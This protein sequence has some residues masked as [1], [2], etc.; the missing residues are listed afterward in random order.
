MST[1][2]PAPTP[3]RSSLP[4]RDEDIPMPAAL[5]VPALLVV[6]SMLFVAGLLYGD[7]DTYSEGENR[8][9]ASW[10]TFSLVA[11]RE[12]RYT[13]AIDD[14][15]ADHFPLREHFLKLAALCKDARGFAPDQVVYDASGLGNFGLVAE[16][17]D[18]DANVDADAGSLTLDEQAPLFDGSPVDVD[19]EAGSLRNDT[20]LQ[21]VTAAG[22]GGV[23]DGGSSLVPS[24]VNGALPGQA[25]TSS[26]MRQARY[27]DGITVVN[28]RA[29]MY[30]DGSDETARTFADAINAWAD[31]LPAHVRLDVLVTPTAT[32]FYLPATQQERS[33]P[34]RDNLETIRRHL[35]PS[36]HWVD[37]ERALASHVDEEVFFRTDHH[38]TGLGAWYAY[39]EWA[40]Q[41][42]FIPVSLA[43]LEKR[44]RP[45]SLGSLYRV[46]QSR[47]LERQPEP[48]DYWLPAI[49]YTAQRWRSLEAAPVQTKLLA[50]RERG[51]AVF[52]GGDDPLLVIE[53]NSHYG[54]RALVVKNS[55][56]N[57]L[58]PLLLPHFDK[59]L[60]IDYRYYGRGVIEIVKKH[61]ISHLLM[62]NAT[63]TANSRPHAHRL[64][65]VLGGRGTAWEVIRGNNQAPPPDTSPA[66]TATP[67]SAPPDVATQVTAQPD[68]A[69]PDP[70]QPDP[71]Q[72][73]PAAPRD[74]A[75][76]TSG[77]DGPADVPIPSPTAAIP[78]SNPDYAAPQR[79]APQ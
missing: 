63:A 7:D 32:H 41:A 39:A 5:A 56:G 36:A 65:E 73:D 12:G 8:P 67:D 45:P 24:V 28:G 11:L 59:I 68:P 74:S 61:K 71:A 76:T 58:V 10:P 29:L 21:A 75:P 27:K 55:Y 57:A 49:G 13:R 31:A 30:L 15:V 18:V 19:A 64:K 62:V 42:G 37:I 77:T 38:W 33:L 52:L 9:L 17:A 53:T 79:E 60:V 34:Q 6:F 16:D 69:Q 23:T 22:G 26:L 70:A 25:N 44:T 1:S 50:E 3:H 2:L 66:T 14:W 20:Q 48:A 54:R 35:R 72:P 40:T 47:V 43:G 51:Y 78:P 46:T 4:T